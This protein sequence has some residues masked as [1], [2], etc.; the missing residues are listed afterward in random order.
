MEQDNSFEEQ[1]AQPTQKPAGYEFTA[2]QNSTIEVLARRMKFLGILNM[3]FA[4]FVALGGMFKLF[5]SPTEA[6]VLFLEVALFAFMGLW[7]YRGA[8]SFQLIVQT[9]GHDITHLMNALEELR[10]IYNLQYWL[11]VI[12]IGLTALGTIVAIVFSM[13][14][15]GR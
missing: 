14:S 12:V 4:G 13:I 1:A 15:G 6:L 5:Q 11:M 3:V 8:A 9:R 2:A 7:N 10:R